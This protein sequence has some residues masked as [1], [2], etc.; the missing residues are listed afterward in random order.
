M[1]RIPAFFLAVVLAM[2]VYY[3]DNVSGSDAHDGLSPATAKATLQAGVNLWTGGGNVTYVKAGAD[4]VLTSAVSLAAGGS[5][6][7]GRNRLEGYTTTPGARDGRPKIT[8]ATNSV[9][10]FTVGGDYLELRHLWLT[11]TAATRGR[12]IFSSAARSAFVIDDCLI[13]GCSYVL[14]NGFNFNGLN[15]LSVLR[16]TV[17]NCTSGAIDMSTGACVVADSDFLGNA[18]SAISDN[19]VGSPMAI[20]VLRSRFAGGQH[21]LLTNAAHQI[22]LASCT[23]YGASSHAV[24]LNGAAPNLRIETNIFYGNAGYG[25]FS[26]FAA[27]QTDANTVR[28]YGNA[29]GANGSGQRFGIS[30]G[31]LDFDLSA[32]PFVNG[33]GGDFALNDIAGAGAACRA[34]ALP[35]PPGSATPDFLDVGGS[36]HQDAGGSTPPTTPSIAIV[37]KG[38]GTGAVATISGTGGA[39]VSVYIAP[40]VAA[41]ANLSFTLAGSRT[42]DGTVPLALSP[43]SYL[44]Y[45]ETSAGSLVSPPSNFPK[46]NATGPGGTGGSGG[47]GGAIAPSGHQGIIHAGVAWL[48]ASSPSWQN[49][50]GVF[51]AADAL[52]HVPLEADDSEESGSSRPRIVVH[53]VQFKL[54][55][56]SLTD[57]RPGGEVWVSFELP[58]DPSIAAETNRELRLRDEKIAFY[59]TV[60]AILADCTALQGTG[61][62]VVSGQSHVAISEIVLLDGPSAIFEEREEGQHGEAPQYFYGATYCFYWKG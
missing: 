57:F 29:F 22:E 37:D 53:Q 10:L 19:G 5:S 14:N 40:V 9:D 6:T 20:S 23:F 62:G 52:A 26:A 25:I 3:V 33:P 61:A 4:Y 31:Y 49:Y 34:L 42:G 38:D 51:S 16:S 8:S 39:A 36:Q 17:Q 30:A 21:A 44:A 7:A 1:L 58:V 35:R 12:A 32:D 13:D 54:G 41:P 27:A 18:G 28:N 24:S 60:D 11:H 2:G 46:F 45:A 50:L 48:L 55:K 43:G 56:V 59:N 47:T 15:P